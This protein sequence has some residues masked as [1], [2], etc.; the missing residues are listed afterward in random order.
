MWIKRVPYLFLLLNCSNVQFSPPSAAAPCACPAPKF[1]SLV[2][3][4]FV[5]S[6]RV[7]SAKRYTLILCDIRFTFYPEPSRRASRDTKLSRPTASPWFSLYCRVA[8]CPTNPNRLAVTVPPALSLP[9][10]S[11]GAPGSKDCRGFLW[12][13]FSRRRSGCPEFT[14]G[15]S[16][17]AGVEGL[18]WVSLV[19]SF[20]RNLSC[21]SAEV[22]TQCIG[23]KAE[24]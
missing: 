24:A 4:R 15:E 8:A 7:L 20:L 21:L 1:C 19:L 16:R 23:T 6:G 12:E 11:P 18:P 17:R 5:L 3:R 2:R 22:P 13:L 14:C 9:V 10:V